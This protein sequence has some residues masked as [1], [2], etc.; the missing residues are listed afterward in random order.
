MKKV[1]MS[2]LFHGNM[3]YDRYTKQEIRDK[4]P[5]IYATGIRAMH[6]FPQVTAHID[7]PGLT[8]LSLK[9]HAPWFMDELKPLVARRQVVMV[10]CQYAASHAL[11]SDEES[12]LVAARLGMEIMRDELQPDVSAFFPQEIAFHPQAPYIMNQVGARYLIVMPDGWKRPRRVKGLDGSTVILYPLDM[13]GCRLGKLEEFFDRHDDGDF[14][15][16]G[17]DFEM[18]GNVRAYVDE[19][20]RLADKGKIIEWMTVDR[21][22][23]EVGIRDECD[24]PSPFGQAAE[25]REPSPS[26]SRWVGDPEDMIWHGHAVRALDAVRS[27]G[28]AKTMA[29]LHGL[30]EVDAPLA[31]ARTTE[32]DNAWDHRFEEANEYPETEEK[33]LSSMGKPTL[34]SRAWHHLLIG[35]NSDSSGWFPWTP[36]TRHRNIALQASCALSS[37]VLLRFAEEV[38]RRVRRPDIPA[39]AFAIAINPAPARTAEVSLQ[40]EAPMGFMDCN[41]HPISTAASLRDGAWSATAR[42]GLPAYG[43]KLLAL[44]PQSAATVDRWAPGSRAEFAG[45]AASLSGSALMIR[46]GE[47]MADVAVAPFRLSDPSGAAATEVVTPNWTAAETR[48]RKTLFGCDLEVFTELAWAVW[49]R[50]IIGLREDRIEIA[51]E[52]HVDMPRRIGNLKYHPEGLLLQFKGQPGRVLYDIPYATIRH[53]ND[54]PSFVAAQRFVA[55]ESGSPFGLIALGGNQ[56]FKVIGTEGVLAA[57]LGASTQGRPDT[58]PECNIRPDG[59]GEHKITSGGDPFLGTYVHRFALVFAGA[60]ET[61]LAARRLRTAVPLFRVEPGKGAW[62]AEKGLLALEPATAHV[63]A[64]RAEACEVVVN[65]LSGRAQRALCQGRLLEL[66]AYGIQTVRLQTGKERESGG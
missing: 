49:L 51:A 10:G 3:C 44:A 22:E 36:R 2:F 60:E 35:L 19:I 28:F 24:A 23:R 30:P 5:K 65:D 9:H 45:R 8:T 64:F 32:P 6:E 12:D 52:V 58:R 34:L 20:K 37:E 66:A 57:N 39:H 38:A 62:P 47:S 61:A 59:T 1:Y 56:S 54:E 25:D 40:V 15:M 14:A 21:Y 50:L 55:M 63:T 29:R 13:H 27:A 46:E 7:F 33:H 11:C 4:F 18:L 42:I 17:G 41:G 43:Y 16:T 31:D 26:F 48:V 53:G